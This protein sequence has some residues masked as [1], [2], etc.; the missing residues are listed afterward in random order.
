MV[1]T[2]VLPIFTCGITEPTEDS[3][4]RWGLWDVRGDESSVP[5]KGTR[6]FLHGAP[7]ST[8][9]SCQGGHFKD[10]RSRKWTLTHGDPAAA[11]TWLLH[12]LDRGSRTVL[13]A[14]SPGCGGLFQQPERLRQGFLCLSWLKSG[15]CLHP[16]SRPVLHPTAWRMSPHISGHV[17]ISPP[18]V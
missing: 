13:A 1:G 7:R 6:S 11:L 12:L 8:R 5:V 17:P 2:L 18:G 9:V 16:D 10:T 14:C 15:F 4:R 3:V